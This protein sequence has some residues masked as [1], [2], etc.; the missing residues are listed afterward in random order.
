MLPHHAKAS[1]RFTPQAAIS[2]KQLRFCRIDGT[3]A[4]AEARQEQV[5][6]ERSLLGRCLLQHCV[7]ILLYP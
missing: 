2:A 6:R 1:Q 3:V 4:T 5:R 7:V